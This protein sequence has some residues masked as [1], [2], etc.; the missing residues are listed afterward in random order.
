MPTLATFLSSIS[1]ALLATSAPTSFVTRRA[2][3]VTVDLDTFFQNHIVVDSTCGRTEVPGGAQKRPYLERAVKDAITITQETQ[4]M[5]GTDVA[6]LKYF[7]PNNIPTTNTGDEEE[8]DDFITVQKMFLAILNMKQKIILKCPL[9]KEEPKCSKTLALTSQIPS[10]SP[11]MDLC[12]SFFT[13]KETK[14]S[15]GDKPFDPSGWCSPPPY[16]LGQFTTGGWTILHEMT[17]LAFIAAGAGIEPGPVKQED[18]SSKIEFVS[19]V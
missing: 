16:K 18:G 10:D 7:L 2:N 14:P 9:V 1:L 13:S 3:A 5:Q 12:P 17:H 8:E 6:F 11:S 4:S 15:L 19:M